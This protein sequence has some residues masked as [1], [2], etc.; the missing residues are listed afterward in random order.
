VGRHVSPH[1]ILIPSQPFLALLA[2]LRSIKYQLY[3]L[4]FDE[5]Q[6]IIRFKSRYFMA[7]HLIYQTT[8]IYFFYLA[9]IFGEEL[10]VIPLLSSSLFLVIKIEKIDHK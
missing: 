10:L 3:S 4:W 8:R 2:L 6:N 7:R 1:I 9:I 5:N